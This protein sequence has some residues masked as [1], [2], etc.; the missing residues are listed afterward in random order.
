MR[1]ITF[2]CHENILSYL[3]E[4]LCNLEIGKRELDSIVKDR[5][6]IIRSFSH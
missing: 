4:R 6:R 3:G 2:S 5:D 1:R